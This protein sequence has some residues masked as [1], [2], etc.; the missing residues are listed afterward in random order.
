M[1]DRYFTNGFFNRYKT[2]LNKKKNIS[3]ISANFNYN[4]LKIMRYK[5]SR[6]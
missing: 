1:L 5:L 3:E 6:E 4:W 2:D